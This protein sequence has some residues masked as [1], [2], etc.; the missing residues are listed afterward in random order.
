MA[1][2]VDTFSGAAPDLSYTRLAG[3]APG[4]TTTGSRGTCSGSFTSVNNRAD[5]DAGSADMFAELEITS[6]FTDDDRS[7]G[8]F[9]RCDGTT[10]VPRGY[11]FDVN[12]QNQRY[13]FGYFTA[14]AYTNITGFVA[15]TFTVPCKIR[16]ESEG[17]QH[18]VYVGTW[19]DTAGKNA[20]LVATYLVAR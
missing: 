1:S 5:V 3:P 18:R 6:A 13:R 16:L 19:T 2:F 11:Q 12:Q 8:V 15:F 17:N 10:T 7:I 20:A 9:T 4:I 14:G